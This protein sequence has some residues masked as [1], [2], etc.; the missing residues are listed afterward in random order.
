MGDA[1]FVGVDW[2]KGGWFSIAC[3]ADG[4]WDAHHGSFEEIVKYYSSAELILVDVPIGIP[5][6]RREGRACDKAAR[7]KISGIRSSF[8]SSVFRV[9]TRD[10]VADRMING[11]QREEAH[12]CEKK[13][14]TKPGINRQSWSI[15]PQIFEVDG[16]LAK[17]GKQGKNIR[18]VHPE[19]CFWAL[20]GKKALQHK[21]DQPE[22]EAERI[23]ILEAR[24]IEPRTREILADALVKYQGKAAP[25]DILDALAA[26]VT[27]RLGTQVGPLQTLPARIGGIPVEVDLSVPDGG[28]P[29][30]MVY[31][32]PPHA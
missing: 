12:Q 7:K 32:N 6:G 3:D 26:A 8:S 15:I 28:L 24:P 17:L 9:P 25:D 19:V 5:V 27:A 30:E 1:K 22:G 18:E 23:R 16:V 14:T 2:A 31:Y 10:A 29:M 13:R 21:K 4:N 11:L 20:N